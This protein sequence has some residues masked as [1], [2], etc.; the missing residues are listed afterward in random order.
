[1]TTGEK[2]KYYRQLKHL[3]Q[4][5]LG[6]KCVKPQEGKPDANIAGSTIRSYERGMLNPKPDTLKIIASAL[7]VYWTDL[8]G[9]DSREMNVLF[10]A[11]GQN[12]SYYMTKYISLMDRDQIK[13]WIGEQVERH[14]RCG[15][16]VAG[17]IADV[18]ISCVEDSKKAKS[19][20]SLFQYY[21]IISDE[22]KAAA[23]AVLKSGVWSSIVKM[24]D[25]KGLIMQPTLYDFE[26]D[27]GIEVAE[28]TVHAEDH[29]EWR[30]HTFETPEAA[31]S[32]IDNY[33]PIQKAEDQEESNEGSSPAEENS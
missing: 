14:Q 30:T 16:D 17:K 20:L 2:I 27:W 18:L 24:A 23:F 31:I 29:L 6:R 5:E 1:M 19:L 25:E 13:N 12:A 7:G 4:D 28:E 22:L 26:D 33:D 8:L 3:T 9:D 11:D 32:F 15:G 21:D 10:E